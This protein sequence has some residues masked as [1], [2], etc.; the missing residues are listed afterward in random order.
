MWDIYQENGKKVW[1]WNVWQ[2]ITDKPHGL[3]AMEM[4]ELVSGESTSRLM[5]V[6]LNHIYQLSTMK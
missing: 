6:F 5:N 1:V 4:C 3:V 2:R